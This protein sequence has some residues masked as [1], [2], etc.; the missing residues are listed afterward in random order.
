MLGSPMNR[1]VVQR[2]RALLTALHKE[3]ETKQNVDFREENECLVLGLFHGQ[4]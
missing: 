1:R 2:F 3:E 4:H